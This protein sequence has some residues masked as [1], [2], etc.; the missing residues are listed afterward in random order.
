MGQ[1]TKKCL[2]FSDGLDHSEFFF[3]YFD[4]ISLVFTFGEKVCVCFSDDSNTCFLG[5]KPNLK[6]CIQ[7]DFC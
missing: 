5:K 4:W 6:V 7:E 3:E 2:V 1:K